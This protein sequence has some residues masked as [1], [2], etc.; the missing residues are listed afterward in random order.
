MS[1]LLPALVYQEV[2]YQTI[3]LNSVTEPLGKS[4]R[5]IKTYSADVVPKRSLSTQANHLGFTKPSN[6]LLL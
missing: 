4:C 3:L 2:F 6:Y 1:K 5:G